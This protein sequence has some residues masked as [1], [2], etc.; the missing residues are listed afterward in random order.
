[1]FAAYLARFLLPSSVCQY[2]N[3]VGLIH[4]ENGY[5]N[6]LLDNW[7]FTSVM[8]GIKRLH[9][10]PHKPKLPISTAILLRI[11]SRLNLHNSKHASFWAICLVSFFGLFRKSHLLPSATSTFNERQFLIRSD[12]TFHDDTVHILVRWSKTIQMGQRT[13]TVPLVGNPCSPLCPLTAVK[14]AFFLTPSA[15]CVDQAF[16]YRDSSA[17]RNVVFTYK[18]FL[19]CLHTLLSECGIPSSDFACHSFRRGGA[20]YALEAGVPLDHIAVMGDWKSD[21]MYLYLH[22]PMRQRLQAQRTI[23]NSL[24]H[25]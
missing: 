1:M 8:K 16:C 21:A 18:A 3:F 6:L 2:I 14:Q 4:K 17:C 19:S 15:S 24:S 20:T 13:I 10:V 23:T 22:M 7:V 25:S 11:H 12:F 9:G 5:A